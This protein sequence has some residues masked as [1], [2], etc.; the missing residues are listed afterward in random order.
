[1]GERQKKIKEKE[2]GV[3]GWSSLVKKVRRGKREENP[4]ELGLVIS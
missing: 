2:G 1:M 4:H 3:L